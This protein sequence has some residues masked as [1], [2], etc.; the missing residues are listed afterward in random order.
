MN[1]S[2]TDGLGPPHPLAGE[3]PA[4]GWLWLG[5]WS[6][7][8]QGFGPHDEREARRAVARALDLGIRHFDTAGVYA[9]G[10]S[11]EL[12]A[13]VLAGSRTG[14]YI[15]SKGGLVRRGGSVCHD[16]RP[17]ALRSALHAS[18]RRLRTDYLDCFQLHWPDPFVAVGESVD[19]LR[20]FQNEGLIRDWGV[21][22][23][24]AQT[25]TQAIAPG[26]FVPHQVHFNPVKP[27]LDILCAGYAQGRCLNCVVSPFEQ[28]LLGRSRADQGLARLG[29]S[30]VRRRNILF[31]DDAVLAWV[32]RFQILVSESGLNRVSVV[33]L[34]L[35]SHAQV[36][37]AVVGA[38]TTEQLDELAEHLT[39]VPMPG[40][41]PWRDDW[42][43]RRIFAKARLGEALWAH[44]QRGP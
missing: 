10:R 19:A 9:Q 39:V 14:V 34:W 6:L 21:G 12:L 11:E 44:M 8:G 18:L 43:R 13:K 7:G 24:D 23:L 29:K 42:E 38:R 40:S 37:C 32:R 41:G 1:P 30:D 5:G 25:L 33:L 20:E 2:P 4:L 3:A 35:F 36:D 27:T 26:A 22:N 31:K 28:G 16:A 15:T 17:E